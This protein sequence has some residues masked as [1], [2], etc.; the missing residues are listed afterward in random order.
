M[1]RFAL[2]FIFLSF[3]VSIL[4]QRHDSQQSL[5][6]HTPTPQCLNSLLLNSSP[7]HRNCGTSLLSCLFI[8]RSPSLF[9]IIPHSMKICPEAND[10]APLLLIIIYPLFPSAAFVSVLSY[11]FESFVLLR[12]KQL[13]FGNRHRCWP[14]RLVLP[15]AEGTWSYIQSIDQSPACWTF[16]KFSMFYFSVHLF[17]VYIH[18]IL[19]TIAWHTLYPPQTFSFYSSLN[20]L[21]YLFTLLY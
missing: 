4:P 15:W 9:L 21:S 5:Q 16:F 19:F 13:S 7:H 3:S 12:F 6:T 20:K 1:S 11:S 2:L 14:V 8:N 10:P 17:A 18:L